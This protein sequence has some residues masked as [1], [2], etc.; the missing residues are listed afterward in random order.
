MPKRRAFRPRR[1][2]G[3]TLGAGVAE[4]HGDQR[5]LVRI[6]EGGKVDRLFLGTFPLAGRRVAGAT[7]FVFDRDLQAPAFVG[8]ERRDLQDG[9]GDPLVRNLTLLFIHPP[10]DADGRLP[11]VGGAPRADPQHPAADSNGFVLSPNVNP[12]IE[13]M[14][15]KEALR[16]YEANLNV[17]SVSKT[18]LTHTV[19]ML[20]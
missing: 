15:M 17:I 2:V 13:L 19:D 8:M 14:D 7:R 5:D 1:Q 16:S 20:K 9:D 3:A 11:H 4:A 12:L 10:F 18:M 6:I